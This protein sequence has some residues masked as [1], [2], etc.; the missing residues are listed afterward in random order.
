M[1]GSTAKLS[2]RP[3]SSALGWLVAA[4]EEDFCNWVAFGR[5]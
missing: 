3:E 1:S 5:P 4:L 2:V